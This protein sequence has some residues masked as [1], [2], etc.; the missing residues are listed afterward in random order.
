M[1]VH[2]MVLALAVVLGWG[3]SPGSAPPQ[4]MP[5]TVEG[6]IT[7]LSSDTL[8]VDSGENIIFRV[9][10]DDKTQIMREDGTAGSVK[11]LRVNLV[12]RV[13][14][15]LSESG[16]ITAQQIA[17]LQKSSGRKPSPKRQP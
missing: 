3:P 8:T 15:S 9:R 1:P 12:V 6:K 11:D 13:E 5:F 7:Q 2:S 10:Y 16:I 4:E 17:I 14:G